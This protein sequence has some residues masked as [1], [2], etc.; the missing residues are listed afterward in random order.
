MTENFCRKLVEEYLSEEAFGKKNRFSFA[1]HDSSRTDNIVE[2]CI[3]FS[4]NARQIY[5]FFRI[6][7]HVL[8]TTM[9][10]D[11]QL[12]WGWQIGAFFMTALS[13]KNRA[14]Y[15]Q[16]GKREISLS[17]FTTFLKRLTLFKEGE[18]HA[19]WWA[20]L[21][22]LGEF[23]DQTLDN[24][25]K[26]FIELGVWD[27]S[28]KKERTLQDEL[29]RFGNPFSQWRGDR[30]RVFSEIYKILEGLRTFVEK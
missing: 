11:T 21:L 10:S 13:I 19:F 12:L 2:I 8:S 24:L 26:E 20:V 29:N 30:I 25:E 27:S 22:Y 9:K 28:D 5:E 18:S 14:L 1:K 7:A 16:I 23:D 6:T 3:A 15:D 17:E 4:L